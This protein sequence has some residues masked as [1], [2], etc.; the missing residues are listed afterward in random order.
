V[1][2]V[3][4]ASTVVPRPIDAVFDFATDP[5]KLSSFMK[6]LLPI[7]G[8][9]QVTVDGDGVS[10]AGARRRVGMSDGSVMGEEILALD[11]P[12]AHAYRWLNPP[13]APFSLLVRGATA[14]WTFAP[15]GG[16]TRIDWVYTFQLTTPLIYPLAALV[17]ARFRG[18]MSAALRGIDG[19]M[20]R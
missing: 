5:T 1:E 16:G 9:Q 19:A 12:R 8:V 4:R 2:L 20:R 17:L 10:R 13:K 15:E 14:E 18:W 11:R 3:T 7:P 6:P